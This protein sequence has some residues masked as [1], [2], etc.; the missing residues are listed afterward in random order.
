MTSNNSLDGSVYAS[1]AA[2]ND[3]AMIRQRMRNHRAS[4]LT[5]DGRM[6][7]KVRDSERRKVQRRATL[8]EREREREREH[9]LKVMYIERPAPRR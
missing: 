9:G 7:E 8:G 3:L 6:N 2:R 1:A 4:V 5:T